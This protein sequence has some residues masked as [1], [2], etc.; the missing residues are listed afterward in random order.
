MSFTNEAAA[1]KPETLLLGESSKSEDESTVGKFG[2]GYKIAALVLN[3]I[4]K[5]FTIYNNGKNEIWCSQFSMSKKWNQKILSFTIDKNITDDNDLVIE[6]GNVSHEEFMRIREIWLYMDG[7]DYYSK[8]ETEYGEI[9]TD[10]E[11]SG[12]VFVNGLSVNILSDMSFGYNFNSKYVTL[13]RDRKTCR[14]WEIGDL[15]AKMIC[16]AVLDGRLDLDKMT[17]LADLNVPDISHIRWQSCEPNT[18]KIAALLIEQ[19]D[20]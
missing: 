2:E 16:Q 1:L 19:F 4:G 10:E 7:K 18:E 11:M 20:Q 17:K 3:R 6:V 13:E 8:I 15:T 9:L 14:D 5:T 12:L